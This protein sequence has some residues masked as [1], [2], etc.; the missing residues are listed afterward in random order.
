[1]EYNV[2]HLI[3]HCVPTI[4]KLLRGAP[5]DRTLDYCITIKMNNNLINSRTSCLACF[6]GGWRPW[7]IIN[8]ADIMLTSTVKIAILYLE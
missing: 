7:Q 6:L 2:N 1:M 3:S 8:G 5:V 4:V